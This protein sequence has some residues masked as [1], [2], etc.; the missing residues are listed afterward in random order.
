MHKCQ[1]RDTV[2]DSS[3]PYTELSKIKGC[4]N[5]VETEILF[6]SDC[7]V[8]SYFPISIIYIILFITALEANTFFI[9]IPKH[10]ITYFEILCNINCNILI[11]T[12]SKYLLFNAQFWNFLKQ[13]VYLFWFLKNFCL[14]TLRKNENLKNIQITY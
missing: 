4:W 1:Y 9:K 5:W 12:F 13:N 11:N 8:L 10:S 3:S 2:T 6:S 7:T 14:F